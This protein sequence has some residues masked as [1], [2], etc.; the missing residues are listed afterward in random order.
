[1]DPVDQQRW[2]DDRDA[3]TRAWERAAERAGKRYFGSSGWEIFRDRPPYVDAIKKDLERLPAG[4]AV[5]LAVMVSFYNGETGGRMLRTLQAAGLGD[6]ALRLEPADR[7][8][9]AELFV[10]FER[11]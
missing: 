8:L 4:Q 7:E 6:I 10:S 3:F 9:V 5:L 1:M 2:T 11:W